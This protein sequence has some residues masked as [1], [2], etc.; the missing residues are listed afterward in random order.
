MR[1]LILLLLLA[2]LAYAEVSFQL[3]QSEYY[4][5]IKETAIIPL[6]I[7]TSEAKT[8]TLSY[9]ITQEINQGNV[10]YQSTNSE[11]LP[12]AIEQGY[13]IANL[14][15]QTSESPA[16]YDVKLDFKY[17]DKTVSLD[18]FQIFFVEDQS[19]QQQSEKKTESQE[20]TQPPPPTPEQK[21]QQK[22]QNS[23][24]S[25]DTKSLKK[26][27]NQRMEQNQEMESAFEQELN[28]NQEF[29]QAQEELLEQGYEPTDKNLNP[30]DNNSGTFD[31]EYERNGTKANIKGEMEDGELK[32]LSTETEDELNSMINEFFDDQRFKTYNEELENK[33]YERTNYTIQGDSIIQEYNLENQT[34]KVIGEFRNDSLNKVKL[35][36]P[37]SWDFL[38]WLLV[39]LLGL[40][41]IKKRKEPQI[42]KKSKPFDFRKESQNLLSESRALFDKRRYKDAYGKASES[43]RLYLSHKHELRKELT[44]T[45]TVA[46]LRKKKEPFKETRDALNMCGMV[47]FAKYKPNKKD[48]SMIVDQAEKVLDRK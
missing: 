43:I 28:E 32:E 24:L 17:D 8:G 44:S 13:N 42:E 46:L 12:Y 14:D 4:F 7:N 22:L 2:P 21:Q 23:Q 45:E 40:L 1:L 35:R 11:S 10:I 37:F 48:F 31:M 3:N 36:E 5:L 20:T 27:M 25:Q 9:T 29:Q 34:A 33:G 39:F 18:S 30:T 6:E 38:P 41:F 15:F 26:E 19:Q 47:E 16:R